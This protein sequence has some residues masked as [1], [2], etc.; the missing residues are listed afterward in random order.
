MALVHLG[1]IQAAEGAAAADC[2]PTL[3]KHQRLQLLG[4]L[5]LVQLQ[6]TA[7]WHLCKLCNCRWSSTLNRRGTGCGRNPCKVWPNLCTLAGFSVAEVASWH[8][9]G[10]CKG[11]LRIHALQH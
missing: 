1:T 11:I 7:L 2:N 9:H 10:H 6:L 3:L 8:S 4:M 5:L